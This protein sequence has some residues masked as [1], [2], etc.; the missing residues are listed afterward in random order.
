M[1]QRYKTTNNVSH[2]LT[3]GKQTNSW[4]R[5]L[6]WRNPVLW[7]VIQQKDNE[8]LA[9]DNGTTFCTWP[10]Y[11]WWVNL[12][13]FFHSKTKQTN[14]RDTK[15]FSFTAGLQTQQQQ[16]QHI[17]SF[18]RCHTADFLKMK[19]PPSSRRAS[20]F[21]ADVVSPTQLRDL[22]ISDAN[23]CA[24]NFSLSPCFMDALTAVFH[25][26]D[27]FP[28]W[29][30][31]HTAST[32]CEL[33]S[34]RSVLA[35]PGRNTLTSVVHTQR[36]NKLLQLIT[37]LTVIHHFNW[38]NAVSASCRAITRRM[39][40]KSCFPSA[41]KTKSLPSRWRLESTWGRGVG[42][43]TGSGP[44]VVIRNAPGI[45]LCHANVQLFKAFAVVA[46]SNVKKAP[47]PTLVKH[48]ESVHCAGDHASWFS[49]E[50][51][52][53]L[54]FFLTCLQMTCM[55][56]LVFTFTKLLFCRCHTKQKTTLWEKIAPLLFSTPT[57]CFSIRR[58]R[59]QPRALRAARRRVI[60]LFGRS[61]E[62][63]AK[64]KKRRSRCLSS[65]IL[66]VHSF[67][68]KR[69]SNIS[70]WINEITHVWEKFNLCGCGFCVTA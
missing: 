44:R 24:G 14:K 4:P 1:S 53:V 28:Q 33:D 39:V 48:F 2:C 68:Y 60:V 27:L 61:D 5:W 19:T 52:F 66:L 43:L 54:F 69:K 57:C 21:G 67:F 9:A 30:R 47:K 17:L 31:H 37:H 11:C 26:S 40:C 38:W 41:R 16:V 55:C 36:C 45:S 12:S 23:I 51:Y 62:T 46:Y 49:T 64:Q 20:A 58:L 22:S 13:F 35:Q 7:R 63:V 8:K 34:D 29:R 70:L 15:M 25:S 10:T 6:T 32:C 3:H 42:A 56:S 18:P 59:M 65:F 50:L